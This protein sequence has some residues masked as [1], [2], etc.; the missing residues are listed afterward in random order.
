[1]KKNHEIKEGNS[2]LNEH[3]NLALKVV[4]PNNI[5]SAHYIKSKFCNNVITSENINHLTDQSSVIL[6][7]ILPNH[8]NN[9][10]S[11][12]FKNIHLIPCRVLLY[13]QHYQPV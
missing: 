3:H 7:I 10:H 2:N 6:R 11:T 13:H 4:N 5:G 8:S 12:K 9:E 1:M